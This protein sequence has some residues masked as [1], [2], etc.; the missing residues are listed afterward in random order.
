ML[1]KQIRVSITDF[2]PLNNSVYQT[3]QGDI[4][5]MSWFIYH[6]F[7]PQRLTR[8]IMTIGGFKDTIERPLI[9]IPPAPRFSAQITEHDTMVT[10]FNL[11]MSV[12]TSIHKTDYNFF[13]R[14]IYRCEFRVSPGE[15]ELITILCNKH[16]A[17]MIRPT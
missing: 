9:F 7:I 14:Y 5:D 17:G 8:R 1:R 2:L 15:G 4:T 12:E 3:E 13:R 6:D 11:P 10:F 16:I